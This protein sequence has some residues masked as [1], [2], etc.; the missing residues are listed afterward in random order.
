MNIIPGEDRIVVRPLEQ[1]EEKRGTLVIA[2]TPEKKKRGSVV[3]V[4]RRRP[5]DGGDPLPASIGDCVIFR[6][7]DGDEFTVD[8]ET[9]FGLRYDSVIATL[10]EG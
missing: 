5:E 1:S 4:G 8:G 7:C 3:A 2:G 10:R 9:Y 6:P